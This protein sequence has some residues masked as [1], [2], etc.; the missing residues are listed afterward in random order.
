MF[1]CV[2]AQVHVYK[3]VALYRIEYIFY[4]FVKLVP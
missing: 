1:V 3:E 4:L 2:C